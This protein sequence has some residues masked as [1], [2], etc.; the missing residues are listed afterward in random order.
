MQSNKASNASNKKVLITQ[1]AELEVLIQAALTMEE[2]FTPAIKEVNKDFRLSARNLLHYLALRQHDIRTLQAAL[3]EKGLSSLGRTEGHVLASLFAVQ[4]QLGISLDSQPASKEPAITFS[5]SNELLQANTHALLGTAP[6]NRNARIMV[7]IPTELASDYDLLC[8]MMLAGMNCARINCAHDDEKVWLE[9]IKNIKRAE[10]ELNLPCKVL[11]DLM[12]PKLRTGPLKPGPKLISI[13]PIRDEQGQVV[14]PANVWLSAAGKEPN[15]RVDS[16]L[17]FSSA[18]VKQLQIGDVLD[19][20]DTRGRKRRLSVV[21]KTAAGVVAHLFKTS[22]IGTGTTMR[23]NNK[24]MP[25]REAE[26]GELPAMEIPITLKKDNFLILHKEPLPGEPAIFDAGGHIIKPAHISCTLPEVFTRVKA[27]QPI[28]FD[29]GKITGEIKTVSAGQ[30]L[31][32]ITAASEKGSKLRANKGINLPD[33]KLNL[34]DL[35]EKDKQDLPFVMKHADIVNLSFVNHP[36]TVLELQNLMEKNGAV[37][38]GIMLKIETK[39][40]FRNLPHLLLAVMRRYPAGIM[41]ARGDLAVE[42]GWERLAE[43]QEE[44]LWLCEAAHMPVVWATQ[45]LETLAKKGRPSRAEITDAAMSQRADCVMLNKGPHVVQ[46]IQM[47][48]EILALMQLHQH[49][50][51]SMLRNLQISELEPIAE[52]N[53]RGKR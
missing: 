15:F 50:K 43:V 38:T 2:R 5:E 19:F 31:I 21:K 20:R 35:T 3:A 41:I 47:L 40:A 13:H 45:V 27:G 26:V 17:P 52:E 1:V 49:K 24:N 25:Q 22:Y 46:A 11:M 4:K 53:A 18:W 37:K 6:A 32:R 29:D 12:G 28:L 51:T 10:K 8:R 36:D 39:E 44:I 7:T 9:M 30:L 14:S 33:S 23:V 48:D 42:C 16:R 34:T